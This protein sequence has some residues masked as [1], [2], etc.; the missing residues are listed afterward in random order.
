MAPPRKDGRQ[1]TAKSKTTGQRCKNPPIPGGTVCRIH[2][3]AAPQVQ[4]VAARRV[5]EAL[6]GPALIQ[7]R[8]IVEDP[9]VSDAVKLAAIRDILDRTGYRPPTELKG[10]LTMAMVEAAIAEK[11][12]ELS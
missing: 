8:R 6:I 2:G 5:L 7:L 9:S 3:G 4:A 12:A 11:E 10:A 1:C